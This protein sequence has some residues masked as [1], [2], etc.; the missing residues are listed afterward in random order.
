MNPINTSGIF[1]SSTITFSFTYIFLYRS[2]TLLLTWK[3][4]N[5]PDPD[6]YI[7]YKLICH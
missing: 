2:Q 6:E 1:P 4:I 3:P 5:D 7:Y